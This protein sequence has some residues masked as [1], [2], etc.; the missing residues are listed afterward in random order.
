MPLDGVLSQQ[1]VKEGLMVALQPAGVSTDALMSVVLM[2]LPSIEELEEESISEGQMRQGGGLAL[3][4]KSL[5]SR[6]GHSA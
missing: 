3:K 5:A 1:L 2:E 4:G 6:V